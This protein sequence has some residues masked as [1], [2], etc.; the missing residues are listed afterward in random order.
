MKRGLGVLAALLLWAGAGWAEYVVI[1]VNLN[2]SET[3]PTEPGGPRFT[4]PPIDTGTNTGS[5]DGATGSPDGGGGGRAP[6]GTGRQNPEEQQKMQE[7][8]RQRMGEMMGRMSGGGGGPGGPSGFGGPGSYGRQFMGGGM[9]PPGQS[10]KGGG[11]GFMAPPP[12]VGAGAPEEAKPVELKPAWFLVVVEADSVTTNKDG[13]YVVVHK[14]GKTT[15]APQ[16][17]NI[18]VKVDII[19]R[20]QVPALDQRL[21]R[22]KTKLLEE[23]GGAA[24][25]SLAG[26]LK[27]ADWMLQHWNLPTDERFL[28]R[29]EF[30]KLI[31]VL[32]TKDAKNPKVQALLATR[33][34]LKQ[35]LPSPEAELSRLKQLVGDGKHRAARGDHYAVLHQPRDERAAYTEITRLE[36]LYAGY[37]YWFALQGKPLAPP[38]EKLMAVL[39]GNLPEFV[40]LHDLFDNLPLVADGFYSRFDNVAVFAATR[41]DAAFLRFQGMVSNLDKQ[42]LELGRLLRNEP[43]KSHDESL[44]TYGRTL[45]LA[46]RAAQEEG[47]VATVSHEAVQQLAVAT[48]VF[49]AK[50]HTPLSVKFGLGSFFE[51]PKSDGL[52]NA[53]S[54]WSGI[55]APSWS[56]LPIFKK[57]MEAETSK[58]HE[59]ALAESKVKKIEP[60]SIL[61][62]ITDRDLNAVEKG[63][64]Q[65]QTALFYKSRAEAW[66]L[67]YFLAKQRLD[68]LL[69][70]Y[71]ELGRLPRD[72]E[73]TD[74]VVIRAFARAFDLTDAKDPSKVDA[75]KLAKLEAAWREFMKYEELELPPLPEPK[76]SAPT[77][78]TEEKKPQK[79]PG[80]ASRQ[81][82]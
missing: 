43:M 72:M 14:W 62:V 6:R 17:G 40:Q 38:K 79:P 64:A 20:R 21:Q 25:L 9:M 19:D 5:P 77:K 28:M 47:D 18:S 73:L 29:G 63:N 60:I 45:A 69:K 58:T 41:G 49:P 24:E 12:G 61:N 80:G 56:Y 50:V 34:Q 32:K 44:V 7:Q 74:E 55:G 23:E 36:H 71:A 27:L 51:T 39:A 53:M 65:E 13:L 48:G 78:P 76:P 66:A 15:I 59:F 4:P 46:F 30:E 82:G 42:N 57:L 2:A 1:R 81:I 22:R 10:A 37:F 3:G 8:M 75:A 11:A 67:N 16:I 26:Q 33:E 52:I 70:F 31:D 35:E 68:Q 54:Y